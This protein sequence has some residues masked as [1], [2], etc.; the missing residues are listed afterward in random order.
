MNEADRRRAGS[1][2]NSPIQGCSSEFLPSDHETWDDELLDFELIFSSRPSLSRR[3]VS[4]ICQIL[5]YEVESGPANMAIDEALLDWVCR[6]PDVAF[7]RTYGWSV[8][9]LSLG[10]FQHLSQAAAEARWQAVPLVRRPTGGGAIWHHRE[11][12]YALVLPGHHPQARPSTLLY[13]GVHAAIASAIRACGLEVQARLQP[14]LGGRAT[15]RPFLCFLDSEPDDLVA[16]TR[17]VVGSAQR[18]RAGAILQHGSILLRRS[19]QTPE[20]LG[21]RDLADVPEDADFWAQAIERKVVESLGLR[22]VSCS[23]STLETLMRHARELARTVYETS[24][25]TARRP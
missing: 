16:L 21:I 18:R 13:R 7:F 6:Q 1:A 8:P 5:P 3:N 23:Q 20:L 22:P 4:I 15:P 24:D 11:I 2:G 25:W 10:Y 17:K 19:E 14:A 12:T 9:T